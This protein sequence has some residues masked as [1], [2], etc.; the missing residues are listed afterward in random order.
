[1]MTMTTMMMSLK[2]VLH[3]G[4]RTRDA[5]TLV[6]CSTIKEVTTAI[7]AS[8]GSV[9]IIDSMTLVEN[10]KASDNPLPWRGS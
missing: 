9:D 1:M 7:D 6:H 4:D 5:V 10:F 2:A 8:G 3:V